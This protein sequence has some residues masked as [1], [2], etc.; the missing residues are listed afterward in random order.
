MQVHLVE[1]T[2]EPRLSELRL[3][4]TRVNRNAYFY[5]IPRTACRD[6]PLS[7]SPSLCCENFKGAD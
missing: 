3:N 2:V 5:A 1:I 6:K 4:E 7:L